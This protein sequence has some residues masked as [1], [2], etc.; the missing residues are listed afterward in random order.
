[1]GCAFSG[2]RQNPG[3]LV[4]PKATCSAALA[5]GAATGGTPHAGKA[6]QRMRPSWR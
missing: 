6:S 4:F 1:M 5:A 3:S 2:V